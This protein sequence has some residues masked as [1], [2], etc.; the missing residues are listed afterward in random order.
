MP[1]TSRLQSVPGLLGCETSSARS[2]AIDTEEINKEEACLEAQ[3][4]LWAT[5]ERAAADAQKTAEAQ[6]RLEDIRLQQMQSRLRESAALM[7]FPE[8]NGWVKVDIGV[9]L[10]L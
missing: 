5:R 4:N 7:G 1:L 10:T 3:A 9:D 2:F 8:L 6:Q